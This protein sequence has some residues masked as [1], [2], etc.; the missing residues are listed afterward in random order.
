MRGV[1]FGF[2]WSFSIFTV[3]L[4]Y[5]KNLLLISSIVLPSIMFAQTSIIS[6]NF[7]SY[8][9]GNTVVAQSAGIW[10]TWTGGGGTLEDP[11]VSNTFSSSASNSMNVYNNGVQQFLHDVVLP[12]P[13]TYTTGIYEFKMKIYVPSGSGGYFN[14]GGAWTT[15]G[16]GFQYQAH[17]YFNTDGSGHIN[18]SGFAVFSYSQ[19][20]WTDVSLMVDL[21]TNTYDAF[22]DGISIGTGLN[23]LN[24]TGG[25]GVVDIFAVASTNTSNTVEAPSNF[26]V[27]D[28]ELL[29]WTSVGVEDLDSDI[30]M[31]I[32]PNPSNGNFVVNL[33][34]IDKGNYT[35]TVND[36]AGKLISSEVL[37]VAAATTFNYDLNLN[38]GFYFLNITNGNHTVTKKIVIK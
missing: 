27:D 17:V 11:F 2:H 4:D 25:I 26:Y 28:V 18:S 9:S 21:G 32:S 16:A 13:S 38:S 19:D 24:G 15:G 5:M 10:D 37:N 1:Y 31:T 14:L 22:I 7:D 33:N 35:L 6:D 8:T 23:L 34:N 12:F 3:K 29:D 36:M 20:V 30:S